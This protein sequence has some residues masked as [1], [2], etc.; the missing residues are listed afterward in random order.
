MICPVC[1]RDLAPTLSICL[2]CGAMMNDTVREELESKIGRTSGPL[3]GGNSEEPARPPAHSEPASQVTAAA[4][5]GITRPATT[6]LPAR[7]TSQ[8]LVE[9]QT[10]NAAVPE[11]RLQ[12]QNVVR[13]RATGA[14]IRE[15]ES[16][17]AATRPSAAPAPAHAAARAETDDR[18]ANALRRIEAS[19]NAFMPAAAAGKPR[20]LARPAAPN[21]NFPF[22]V[23]SAKP[24][25]S[26]PPVARTPEIAPPQKP[27]LV[28]PL[29]IEKK[30][31]DTNKLPPLPIPTSI[32]TSFHSGPLDAPEIEKPGPEPARLA[33]V[34]APLAEP[35]IDTPVIDEEF[36]EIDDLAPFSMRFGAGLFDA[37]IAG[38]AALII[39][40][41][42]MVSGGSWLSPSGML[43]FAA[44][45]AILSFLY[46]TAAIGFWGKTFGMRLFSLELIDAEDNVYPTVHQA[47]VNSAVYLLSMAFAGAGFLTIPFNQEKR[48][49]H[50]I[51]SG[52]IMVREI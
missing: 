50:D 28:S 39:L 15:A 11:W 48:A 30:G 12:L 19:R 1:K 26:R 35:D 5:R 32:S 31:F 21:R 9:F 47:A 13:K 38:F 36:D 2:T 46:F 49:L 34:K 25:S 45:L 43:A 51:V 6:H 3:N 24:G 52:T 42:L 18:V 16:A 41:P 14:D 10:R 37:I 27:K 20:A 8:T 44:A 23:V 22:D 7:H 4:A 29:K 33:S 40:S 17:N